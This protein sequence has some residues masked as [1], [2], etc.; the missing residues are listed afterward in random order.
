MRPFTVFGIVLLAI[1][2]LAWAYCGIIYA[3][4]PDPGIRFGPTAMILSGLAVFC[5]IILML[6]GGRGRTT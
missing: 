2:L 3:T 5:G 6:V 4:A 1:G